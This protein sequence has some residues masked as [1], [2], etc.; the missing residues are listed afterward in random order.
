MSSPPLP[1]RSPSLKTKP[2]GK[3]VSQPSIP[4]KWD[5]TIEGFKRTKSE[6]GFGN[7]VPR[8]VFKPSDTPGPGFYETEANEYI[9]SGPSIS[10]KG[11][12]N[13]FLSKSYRLK[14]VIRN[15]ILV[16]PGDY[17]FNP[18]NRL[19]DMTKD[20]ISFIQA[21]NGKGRVP[22][23]EPLPYPGVGDYHL[24]IEPGHFSRLKRLNSATF[25]SQSGRDSYLVV[26]KEI[27]PVGS[28]DPD[29]AL[30]EHQ[31]STYW[32]LSK[33][34]RFQD[35]GM[36]NKVPGPTRYFD[37]KR[38]QEEEMQ[39]A[40]S[41]GRILGRIYSPKGKQNESP[42][43][44]LHTFGAD[45]ERFKHSFCGR[46][47]LAA[48][49]PGPGTYSPVDAGTIREPDPNLSPDEKRRQM[50]GTFKMTGPQTI[51]PFIKPVQHRPPGPAYYNPKP[52]DKKTVPLNP[53]KRWC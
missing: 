40:V 28:Y 39:R 29:S 32:S 43:A 9:K 1:I 48:Q 36:D 38:E 5:A 7:R 2:P 17:D 13:A 22:F 52:I 12:S 33:H 4:S 41:S 18:Y 21:D 23:P 42:V 31:R 27:P 49:F 15:D 46:L 26:S 45:V 44:S 24:E 50:S 3:G 51:A 35:L 20:R 37:D 34:T 10:K 47:D 30:T 53:N 11:F 8:F 16:G 6:K 25:K 19:N 14:S